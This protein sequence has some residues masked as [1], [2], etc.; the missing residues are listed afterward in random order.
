MAALV[1]AVERFEVYLLGHAFTVYTDHQPLVSAFIVHLKSQ[2]RGLLARWYLRLARF[3]PDMKIEYKPGATN[4]VAYALSRAP[5][6]GNSD[7]TSNT[8][9]GSNVFAVE[10]NS[11]VQSPQ[12]DAMLQQVQLEQRKDSDLLQFIDFLTD[13]RLPSDTHDAGMVVKKGYY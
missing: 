7:G 1:Y 9:E 8:T 12:P 3:L 10:R 6:L 4:V 5:T 11:V 2:T 13:K